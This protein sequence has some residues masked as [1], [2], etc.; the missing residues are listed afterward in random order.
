MD[1]PEEVQVQDTGDH[2]NLEIGAE[3]VDN[4][5]PFQACNVPEVWLNV[6]EKLGAKDKPAFSGACA[7]WHDW[8]DTKRPLQLFPEVAPILLMNL[9]QN[10]LLQSRE[11]CRS[12]SKE[13]DSQVQTLPSNFYLDI[14]LATAERVLEVRQ[15]NVFNTSEQIQTF[16]KEM[17]GHTGNPFPGRTLILEPHDP[18]HLGSHERNR[19]CTN[20]WRSVNDL[21]NGMEPMFIKLALPFGVTAT[22]IDL[23]RLEVLAAVGN[24]LNL[25]HVKLLY[26]EGQTGLP[27]TQIRNYFHTNPLTQ[28]DDL[29]TM[30]FNQLDPS[31]LNTVLH[32]CCVPAKIRR[33]WTESCQHG[34]LS[35]FETVSHF[36]NLEISRDFA[37]DLRT[38]LPPLRN[39]ELGFFTYN[40]LNLEQLFTALETFRET[41]VHFRVNSWAAPPLIR[42]D[43]RINLPNL[44]R[45]CFLKYLGQLQP[46]RQLT[47]LQELT[48]IHPSG[49]EHMDQMYQS[50]IWEL[51]PSLQTLIVREKKFERVIFEQQRS[52]AVGN[53]G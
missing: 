44:K 17:E 31:L 30:R 35:L 1:F 16:L 26:I 5:R 46:L 42:T 22:I 32:S 53:I 52:L 9:P 21:V 12:W 15:R 24:C 33:F 14:E 13:L 28:L 19:I 25:P 2:A 39:L 49:F 38:S 3:E 23:T 11:L 7:E 50:N 6:F 8:V 10:A 51:V 20:Y 45:L 37:T 48:I 43:W 47:A 41:L 27:Q 18:R 36:P 40:T 29:E 34:R 4:H